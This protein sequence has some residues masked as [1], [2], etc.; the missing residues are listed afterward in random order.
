M[1]LD[2]PVDRAFVSAQ[3]LVHQHWRTVATDLGLQML[4]SVDGDGNYNAR[5]QLPASA[6]PGLY[7]LVVT[8]KRYRVASPRF[9]VL[10]NRRLAL[11]QV[12]AAPGRVAV[13]LDYPPVVRDLDLVYRPRSVQGG[14]VRFKV[15]GRSVLV[16][17][18]RGGVFSVAAPAGASVSVGGGRA[19]DRY[20]NFA[21][22]G[23]QLVP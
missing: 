19:R 1:G 23:A 8:A 22:T 17:S 15:G 20:G 9:R 7:R 16:R 18:R 5:W 6:A 12:P 3:R 13:A 21:G 2:R 14:A 10:A 4:W 11:R